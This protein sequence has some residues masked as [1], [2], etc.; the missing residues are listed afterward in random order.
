IG[1]PGVY[2]SVSKKIS[3]LKQESLILKFT[4]IFVSLLLFF[5]VFITILNY[6]ERSKF[7]LAVQTIHGY[8]FMDK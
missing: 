2:A 5:I 6:L 7:V 8:S 1:T 4:L 3:D